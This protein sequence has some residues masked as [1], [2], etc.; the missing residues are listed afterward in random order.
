[1]A[2]LAR[3]GNVPPDVYRAMD[4][5]EANEMV[6]RVMDMRN[7]DEEQFYKFFSEMIKVVVQSNGARIM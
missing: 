6:K 7:K 2:R 4:P 1:M 3:Y 5:D